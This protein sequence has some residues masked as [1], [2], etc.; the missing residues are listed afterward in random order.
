MK[1]EE[2]EGVC[3][4]RSKWKEVIFAYPNGRDVMYVVCGGF[5]KK[6]PG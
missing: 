6:T 2:A 4:H 1:I 5:V 3:K